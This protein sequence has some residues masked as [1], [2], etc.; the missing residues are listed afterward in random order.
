MD[1]RATIKTALPTGPDLESRS[2]P[3]V[4]YPAPWIR[5]SDA[6]REA[7]VAHLR[8]AAAEGRLT[9][10]EFSERA[11]QAYASRTAGELARLVQDLP[12]RPARPAMPARPTMANPPTTASGSRLPPLALI[13]G[14]VSVPAMIVAPLGGMAAVAAI[15]LG[16][17]SLGGAARGVPGGRGMAV[18]GLLCGSLALATQVA[19]I[20]LFLTIA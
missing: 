7:A 9:L 3:V 17:L 1:V 20:V 4:M 18:A 12:A 13:F 14:V 15:V 11:R 19:M 16:I 2:Y 10:D 5:V 6:D 8:V